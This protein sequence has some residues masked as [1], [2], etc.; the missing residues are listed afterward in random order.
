MIRI[1]FMRKRYKR[2]KPLTSRELAEGASLFGAWHP[3]RTINTP[4]ISQLDPVGLNQ[5]RQ[6][7]DVKK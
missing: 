4:R 6:A 7:E 1:F 3:G 2:K 5:D